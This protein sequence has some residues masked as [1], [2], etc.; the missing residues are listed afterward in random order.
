M[1]ALAS[2]MRKHSMAWSLLRASAHGPQYPVSGFAYRYSD[3][4]SAEYSVSL[5]RCFFIANN[6]AQIL[7]Q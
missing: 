6:P 1:F 2:C 4:E 5:V 7:L 3:G